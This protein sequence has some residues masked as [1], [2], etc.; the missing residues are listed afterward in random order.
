M[1]C[2]ASADWRITS[3]TGTCKK[4]QRVLLLQ[5]LTSLVAYLPSFPCSIPVL[6]NEGKLLISDFP[7]LKRSEQVGVVMNDPIVVQFLD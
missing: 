4:S 2:V 6:A 5:L 7:L 3:K 1:G